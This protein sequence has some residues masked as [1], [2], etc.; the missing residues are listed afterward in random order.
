M[1]GERGGQHGVGPVGGAAGEG[2]GHSDDKEEMD[3]EDSQ[4]HDA[5][6]APRGMAAGEG[7]DESME[8]DAE[9]C[10]QGGFSSGEPMQAHTSDSGGMAERGRSVQPVDVEMFV[11][12]SQVNSLACACFRLC[13]CCWPKAG[14]RCL[15]CVFAGV[16]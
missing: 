8:E 7:A 14:C 3:I 4:G 1:G 16:S 11:A 10:G 13:I 2:E 9:H 5:A 12:F 6:A 15:T